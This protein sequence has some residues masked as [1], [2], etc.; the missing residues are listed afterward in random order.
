MSAVRTAAAVVNL[1]LKNQLD[2]LEMRERAD[3]AES[4]LQAAEEE[5]RLGLRC[6]FPIDPEVYGLAIGK[7]GAN[8]AR[9]LE[10][11]DILI[12][13]GDCLRYR[14]TVVSLLQA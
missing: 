6:E 5:L 12:V 3:R 10:T 4:D 11:G 7:N 13:R 9:A 2:L 8:I 1:H 14:V